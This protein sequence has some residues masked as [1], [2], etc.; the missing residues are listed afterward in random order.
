MPPTTSPQAPPDALPGEAR[1]ARG[2]LV[3]RGRLLSKLAATGGS[4]VIMLV[5]PAG[6][7]KSTILA[8]WAEQD[9]RPSAWLTLDER[10]NDPALLLGAIAAL[11]HR[12]EPMP[13]EVFAPLA[14]ARSGVSSVAAPRIGEVIRS[15][16]QPFILILDDLHLVHNPD[17]VDPLAA[18][19]QAVPPGS[20]IAIASRAEPKLPLG[21]M[22][23]D[24]M[25]SEF[26]ASDLGM[27]AAEAAQTLEACGLEL[28]A[29]SVRRLVERTEGWPV[30][31]Y[32]AGLSLSNK[33][34]VEAAIA[35]FH[36]D[37]RLVSD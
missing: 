20:Q 10:H 16:E 15:R 1:P 2:G 5:A 29:D 24:R 33:P 25:L 27:D 22:R 26:G 34:K 3:R 14:T 23:A 13:E 18:I 21:R 19:L 6:Y 28:R 32:L 11:L 30:G 35:D 36:G 8:D 17:C 31:L 37:D 4:P 7:G 9:E 12:I